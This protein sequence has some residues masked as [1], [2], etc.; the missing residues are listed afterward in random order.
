[1]RNKIVLHFIRGF[2]DYFKNIFQIFENFMM[3]RDA[4]VYHVSMLF[5]S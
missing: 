5:Y 3:L 2:D 1:M 4:A